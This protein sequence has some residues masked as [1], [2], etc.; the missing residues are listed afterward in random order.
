VV[1]GETGFLVEPGDAAGLAKY[2]IELL[3][4]P[5]LRKRIGAAGRARVERL[6]SAKATAERFMVTLENVMR[7]GNPARA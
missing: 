5:D 6:F 1:H 3:R 2:V 7:R 4:D